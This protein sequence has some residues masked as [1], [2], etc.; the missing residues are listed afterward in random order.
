MKVTENSSTL[1]YIRV[2]TLVAIS[3]V[4][5]SVKLCYKAEL[6]SLK[7]TWLKVQFKVMVNVKSL[8]IHRMLWVVHAKTHSAFLSM[9]QHFHIYTY[10]HYLWII[11][12]ILSL[13][14]CHL[15]KPWNSNYMF[16]HSF[17]IWVWWMRGPQDTQYTV[18]L[19]CLQNRVANI[20]ITQQVIGETK[21]S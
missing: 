6:V 12:R 19:F 7:H 5:H 9:L 17:F 21:F 4:R 10:F 15:W 16:F 14:H 1:Q 2:F 20:L 13:P 11:F 8:T 18:S 3:I